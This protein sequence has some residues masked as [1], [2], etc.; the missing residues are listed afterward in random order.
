MQESKLNFQQKLF[1]VIEDLV[2]QTKKV[3]F[4]IESQVT[5]LLDEFTQ[6]EVKKFK[7][8]IDVKG[9]NLTN[10]KPIPHGL[11]L[12]V[13]PTLKDNLPFF[14]RFPIEKKPIVLSYLAEE[15]QLHYC[16]NAV[17]KTR[18]DPK[19][20]KLVGVYKGIP[21]GS[22]ENIKINYS[23]N[24]LNYNFK[25]FFSPYKKSEPFKDIALFQDLET[26]KSVMVSK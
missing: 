20:L 14:K 23:T 13:F 4:S 18:K 7:F 6:V 2:K 11:N 17:L 1:A 16:K 15:E 19:K 24:Y 21:R 26:D 9:I 3:D 12:T 25:T 10:L 5:A 8:A 22:I